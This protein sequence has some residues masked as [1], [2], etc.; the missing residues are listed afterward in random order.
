MDRELSDAIAEAQAEF[1]RAQIFQQIQAELS[2]RLSNL[3]YQ[4]KPPRRA[5]LSLLRT[6]DS[7]AYVDKGLLKTAKVTLS[8][9]LAIQAF[10][11][12]NA[13]ARTIETLFPLAINLGHYDPSVRAT[14]NEGHE[15]TLEMLRFGIFGPILPQERWRQVLIYTLMYK[16]L[17]WILVHE[18]THIVWGHYEMPDALRS[19]DW[20]AQLIESQSDDFATLRFLTSLRIFEKE[21]DYQAKP[22]QQDPGH[23]AFCKKSDRLNITLI[24]MILSIALVGKGNDDK[25]FSDPRSPDVPK[26]SH[27][28]SAYRLWRSLNLLTTPVRTNPGMPP[29][30]PLTP[31]TDGI[32]S[33][34]DLYSFVGG[35]LARIS[36][37]GN[38]PITRLDSSHHATLLEYNQTLMDNLAPVAAYE[39]SWRARNIDPDRHPQNERAYGNQ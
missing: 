14:V 26:R 19:S 17:E 21:H 33:G 15:R 38:G 37:G 30:H 7:T 1:L 32:L 34:R 3:T 18:T 22:W 2:F 9:G 6:Y 12:A 11:Y 29:L 20:V 23:F 36:T 4:L 28:P 35:L 39:A 24:S 5:S 8:V 27:P 10:Y 31:A 16:A 25:F 13:V